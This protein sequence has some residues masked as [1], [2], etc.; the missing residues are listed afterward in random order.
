VNKRT[1][2][3]TCLATVVVASLAGCASSSNAADKASC[4]PDPAIT[5]ITP[6]TLTVGVT[7]TPPYSSNT[8][9]GGA[10]GIDIEIVGAAAKNLC[11]A[12]KYVPATYS[13]S[14]PLI[15]N[16]KQIDIT[17]GAWYPTTTR[18]EVVSF[19]APTTYDAMAIV[20]KTGMQTVDEL[21]TVGTIGTVGGYLWEEDLKTLLGDKLKIY[22]SSTTLSQDLQNGRLDAVVESYGVA[23]GI[24]QE[25]FVFKITDPDKRVTATIEAAQ[26]VY[27]ITK[28]NTSLND[29]LSMQI[30]TFRSDGTIAGILEKQ[31]FSKDLV[32]PADVKLKLIG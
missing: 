8:T 31:G 3:M 4:T 29:A 20:T 17:T 12:I 32:I 16:Q 15:A 30:E 5:T 19:T 23:A 11:L 7:D 9:G 10:T 14:I 27:P 22:Q 1:I 25:P 18:A 28:D 6:G 24:Y 26:T 13:N 2:Y 21:T